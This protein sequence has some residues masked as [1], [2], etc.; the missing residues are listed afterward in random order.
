MIPKRIMF[1]SIYHKC[2]EVYLVDTSHLIFRR[3]IV[4]A[5][6]EILQLFD[7]KILT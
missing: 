4:V 7:I 2:G 1:C 6:L 3:I 5:A